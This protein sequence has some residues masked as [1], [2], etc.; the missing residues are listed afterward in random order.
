MSPEKVKH[1]LRDLAADDYFSA[2]TAERLFNALCERLEGRINLEESE[3]K[4]ILCV[5]AD[6]LGRLEDAEKT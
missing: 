3:I 1:L 5:I 6:R 4:T 2:L